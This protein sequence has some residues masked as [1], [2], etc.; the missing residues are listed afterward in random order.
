MSAELGHLAL[1]LAMLCGVCL[2]VFPSIGVWRRDARLMGMGS[3]AA[4]WQLLLVMV[5]FV[6]LIKT[7]S[8]TTSAISSWQVTQTE[9]FPFGIG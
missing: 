7:L 9:T 4:Y 3:P 5:A 1:A 2:A 8:V 6:C